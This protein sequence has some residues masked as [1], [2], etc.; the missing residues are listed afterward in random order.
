[1]LCNRL[2]L[3]K[4]LSGNTKRNKRRR[5]L[6]HAGSNHLQ[7]ERLQKRHFRM[8]KHKTTRAAAQ[9][10]QQQQQ[11]AA[12]VMLTP[13]PAKGSQQHTG[14]GGRATLGIPE[15]QAL[16]E[17]RRGPDSHISVGSECCV[18]SL[19]DVTGTWPGKALLA[20][21][22]ADRNSLVRVYR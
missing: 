7:R 19:L 21:P 3:F 18:P 1:M 5:K 10:Q 14:L 9:K 20:F 12:Q 22:V 2:K 17:L 6:T 8:C 4:W 15:V 16:E 11:S 13:L